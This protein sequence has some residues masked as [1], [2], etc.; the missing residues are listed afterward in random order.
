[1]H[2]PG[3]GQVAYGEA[4]DMLV[5]RGRLDCRVLP[6]DYLGPKVVHMRP[7][8]SA[9]GVAW[10]AEGQTLR[11]YAVAKPAWLWCAAGGR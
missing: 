6:A 3:V 11:P 7:P 10:V 8:G 2:R 9:E 4:P 5:R 1:M